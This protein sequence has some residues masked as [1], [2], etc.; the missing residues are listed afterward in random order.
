MGL[1]LADGIAMCVLVVWM[2][3]LRCGRAWQR[4]RR[5]LL[6]EGERLR[7]RRRRMEMRKILGRRGCRF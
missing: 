6:R 1:G 4:V 2:G 7:E 3:A 5:R